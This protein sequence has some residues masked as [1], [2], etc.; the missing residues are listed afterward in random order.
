VTP[1]ESSP[2]LT[3][4][5]DAMKI[6]VGSPK[7]PSD[8][9]SSNARGPERERDAERHHRDGKAIPDEDRDRRRQDQERDGRLAHRLAGAQ[10][11]VSVT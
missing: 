8:C 4:N 2:S 6:T 7:P 11:R 5:R 10:P 3:T 1:L 9:S